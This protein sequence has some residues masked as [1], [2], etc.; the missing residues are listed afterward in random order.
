MKKHIPNL[1]TC[2][3]VITGAF[4]IYFAIKGWIEIAAFL[5]LLAALFDFLDGFAARLLKVASPIG[6]DLDSLADVVSFGLTPAM[7]MVTWLQICFQNL[8][9]T[10]QTP[11]I[12]FLTFTPFII[13]AFSAVRLAKFNHDDRQKSSFLGL[14]TP[15]NALFFAFIPFSAETIPFLNNFWIIIG[16]VISFSLLLV[17]EIKLFSLKFTTIKIKPNAMR[18]SFL[19]L[20][21]IILIFFQF[22][23]FPIII[24]SYI[25]LSLASQF[26]IRPLL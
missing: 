23:A 26:I 1:L 19:L 16:F 25:L 14:P 22:G 10:I 3:N 8:S 17:I 11:W 12:E 6:V 5:I 4:S 2:C 18:Y 21:L 13:P 7:I 20:S 15:A 24:L 9:P